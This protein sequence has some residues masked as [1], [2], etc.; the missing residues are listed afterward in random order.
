MKSHALKGS[1][2]VEIKW[3]R[4]RLGGV[5]EAVP[6]F[7]ASVYQGLISNCGTVKKEE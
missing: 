7:P 6:M 5:R 2:D 1:D 3:R 4:D